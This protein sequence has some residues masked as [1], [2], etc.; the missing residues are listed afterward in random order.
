M[1][2]I[3]ERNQQAAQATR[4]KRQAAGKYATPAQKKAFNSYIAGSKLNQNQIKQLSTH[5]NLSIAQRAH[6]AA[7]VTE[8]SES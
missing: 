5:P 6:F 4:A 3:Q 2:I 7:L 8:E 1:T